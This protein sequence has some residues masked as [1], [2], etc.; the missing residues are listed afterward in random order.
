VVD[1]DSGLQRLV[2]RYRSRPYVA[3]TPRHLPP[4]MLLLRSTLTKFCSATPISGS[5]SQK[6]HVSNPLQHINISE[7]N[8]NKPDM[9][10]SK[11]VVAQVNAD[12]IL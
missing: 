4:S 8:M 11:H 12:N 3:G 6:P 10:T 1:A 7:T 9:L 2:I 5:K